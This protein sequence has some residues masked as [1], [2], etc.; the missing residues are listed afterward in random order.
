VGERRGKG[1]GEQDQ[2]RG[3]IGEKPRELKNTYKYA[4]VWEAEEPLESPKYQGCDRLPG[5]NGDDLSQNAQ[6]TPVDRHGLHF[7]HEATCPSS[8]FLTQNC[9][10]KQKMDGPKWSR[11]W[12]SGTKP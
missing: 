1:K 12:R 7:R 6:P 11:D 9:F 2:V 8:K 10:Y 3:H 4:A 5:P